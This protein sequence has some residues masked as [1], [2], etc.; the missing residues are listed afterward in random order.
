[1]F[2]LIRGLFYDKISESKIYGGDYLGI[3]GSAVTGALV[4]GVAS[5]QMKKVNNVQALDFN[6][7]MEIR[8]NIRGR[9][10]LSSPFLKNKEQGYALITQLSRVD[11]INKVGSDYRTG[12]MLIEYDD[13]KV[14]GELLIGAVIKLMGLENPSE[15]VQKSLVMK[16]IQLANQA[17][18]MAILDKTKGIL[19]L[20]TIVPLT[21]LGLAAKS[22]ANTGNLGL[23]A[24]I[25]LLYWSYKTLELGKGGTIL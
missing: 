14:E 16:E 20:R 1:M 7:Q 4:F 19:D 13:S 6:G 2:L 18:N 25:T 10:R 22:Y 5:K 8:Q 12:S 24:P 9:L 23:P 3:L 21:F 11:G 17:V 15:G